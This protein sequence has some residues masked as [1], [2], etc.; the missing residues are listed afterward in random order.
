[1]PLV[2]SADRHDATLG[3]VPR[4]SPSR[5]AF[6]VLDRR[7][8]RGVLRRNAL[9]KIRNEAPAHHHA[10]A[11]T[12]FDPDYRNRLRWSNV[13]TR[14]EAPERPENRE[15]TLNRQLV[16]SDEPTAHIDLAS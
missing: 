3:A 5:T 15:F 12:V 11:L 8:N 10:G 16:C 6:Q 13:V 7:I 4:T 2:K 1:M 14:R 9:R